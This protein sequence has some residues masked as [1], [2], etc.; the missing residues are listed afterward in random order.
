MVSWVYGSCNAV[1]TSSYDCCIQDLST[2]EASTVAEALLRDRQGPVCMPQDVASVKRLAQ[3]ISANAT[4]HCITEFAFSGK[5]TPSSAD[6]RRNLYFRI[7]LLMCSDLEYPSFIPLC[8]YLVMACVL[9]VL[10]SIQNK[11]LEASKLSL[12][13]LKLQV[14]NP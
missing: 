8:G 7:I 3:L 1:A 14:L 2:E 6:L 5:C 13:L 10:L 4:A 11:H 12:S 9:T